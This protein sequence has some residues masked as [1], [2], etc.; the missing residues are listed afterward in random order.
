MAL[1]GI[2]TVKEKKTEL[3]PRVTR[4]LQACGKEFF[5]ADTSQEC[6]AAVELQMKEASFFVI[7][8]TRISNS[9]FNNDR[10]PS[11]LRN[12]LVSSVELI[13]HRF[14]CLSSADLCLSALGYKDECPCFLL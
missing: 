5:R 2:F 13:C 11:Q 3:T 6:K 7:I 8:S 12:N 10:S 14:L 4:P 1:N 9:D